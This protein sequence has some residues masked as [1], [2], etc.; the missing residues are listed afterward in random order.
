MDS[1]RTPRVAVVVLTRNGLRWL[2]KCLSSV[3][4]T[5]YRNLDVYVVDNASTDGSVRYVRE[6][7]PDVKIIVHSTNLGFAAGYDLALERIKADYVVLLNNDTE[8][9]SSDWVQSLVKVAAADPKIAAVGCKMVSMGQPDRLDSVGGMGIPFWR[10]FVDIG[11][12]EQDEGQYDSTGF[13]PFSFCGGA[14]LLRK[15]VFEQAGGFDEKFFMY[16]EDVDLSWRLRLLGYEVRLAPEAKVAHFFS[17]STGVKSVDARK[18][19]YCHRNLLRAI[20]K[21]CGASLWWALRNYLLFWLITVVGFAVLE[22][23]KG[24]AVMKAFLWNLLELKDTY[25]HRLTIQSTRKTGDP[26]ILASMYPAIRK[27]W[28]ACIRR[29]E[30]ISQMIMPSRGGSSTLCSRKFPPSS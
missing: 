16:V 23:K 1:A 8:V 20:L 18:L 24:V 4:R 29:L 2:P 12:E 14:A 27:Y 28:Q 17:G 7:F 25:S 11:R 10:G 22:P 30:D 9:L 15:A 26:K 21:N 13:E 5:D 19:Y 3:A 6:L